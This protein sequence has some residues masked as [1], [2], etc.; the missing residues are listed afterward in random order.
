MNKAE[1]DKIENY[2]EKTLKN[3]DVEIPTLETISIYQNFINNS[4]TQL[5]Q[6]HWILT[7]AR[8]NILNNETYDKSKIANIKIIAEECR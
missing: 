6:N 1:I 5:H 7:Q 4:K 2:Y 3:I 8:L